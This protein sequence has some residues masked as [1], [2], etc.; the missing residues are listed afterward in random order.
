MHSRKSSLKEG[1]ELNLHCVPETV[2]TLRKSVKMR[3]WIHT[4]G[5]LYTY[6]I[7]KNCMLMPCKFAWNVTI[8]THAF[9]NQLED[10]RK[11]WL[12]RFPS[13][14]CGLVYMAPVCK[15]EK[16]RPLPQAAELR[17]G[18]GKNSRGWTSA[19]TCPLARSPRAWTQ[20]SLL[21]LY[22]PHLCFASSS[23]LGSDNTGR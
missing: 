13:A 3:N 23:L 10:G 15:L 4:K 7:A 6:M 17:T 2:P 9:Y 12:L 19:L 11:I 5:G 20:R 16:K 22:K 8:K 14:V 1:K 21:R 18:L